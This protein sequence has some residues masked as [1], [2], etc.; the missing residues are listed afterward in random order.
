MF[1]RRVVWYGDFSAV[2]QPSSENMFGHGKSRGHGKAKKETNS[3]KHHIRNWMH[4]TKKK[5][6]EANLFT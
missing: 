2:P 5:K 3:K 4:T 6:N 1:V